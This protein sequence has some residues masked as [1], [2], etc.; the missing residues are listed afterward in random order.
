MVTP[1]RPLAAPLRTPQA[2]PRNAVIS[3]GADGSI[4]QGTGMGIAAFLVVF[5][6]G[7][8]WLAKYWRRQGR[9]KLLS[10]AG[11]GVVT[12]IVGSVLGAY[13]GG[14]FKDV[15]PSPAQTSTTTAAKPNSPAAL[16][17]A[18]ARSASQP[19][20]ATETKRVPAHV[21]AAPSLDM[22]L[23]EYTIRFN[24]AAKKL[25]SRFRLRPVVQTDRETGDEQFTATLSDAMKIGGTVTA[26]GKV[27]SVGL[28]GDQ[29]DNDE[30]AAEQVLVL[31]ATWSAAIKDA[32]TKDLAP[33]VADLMHEVSAR[34]RA[35]EDKFTVTRTF[36][37]VKIGIARLDGANIY[38]ASPVTE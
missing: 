5:V 6:G 32:N 31:M 26:T 36:N 9:G 28:I 23:D 4:S 34:Q 29:T 35:G 3:Y 2:L 24:T 7:W 25:G 15:P 10:V 18:I 21:Y 27:D 19:A 13:I 37:G 12:F 20:A 33:T 1:F 14:A 11:A 22:S 8:V 17:P 38:G 30:A 16:T